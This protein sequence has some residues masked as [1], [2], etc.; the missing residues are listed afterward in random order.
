[1]ETERFSCPEVLFNPSDVGI[2]QAGIAEATAMSI[3]SLNQ[4]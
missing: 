3:L 4:V 1:M 2:D